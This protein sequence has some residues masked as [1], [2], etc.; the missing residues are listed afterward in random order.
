MRYR[1]TDAG[2]ERPASSTGQQ[3]FG[4]L[5][6]SFWKTINGQ[7]EGYR[8]VWWDLTYLVLGGH[9]VQF[10]SAGSED[11][12]FPA[13]FTAALARRPFHFPSTCVCLFLSVIPCHPAFNSTLTVL[14]VPLFLIVSFSN[15]G[16]TL[17]CVFSAPTLQWACTHSKCWEK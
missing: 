12:S 17:S 14:Y 15:E 13:A 4:W 1:I 3:V 16:N 5:L 6:H 7:G 10:P 11:P 2:A 8:A 9:R